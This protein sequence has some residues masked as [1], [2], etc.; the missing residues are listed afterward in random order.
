AGSA[1]WSENFIHNAVDAHIAN[2][3]IASQAGNVEVS[4]DSSARIVSLSAGIG[5]ATGAALNASASLNTIDSRIEAGITDGSTLSAGQNVEVSAND[6]SKIQAVSLSLSG[7]IGA[8]LG[9]A[10]VT[11]TIGTDTLAY[12]TGTSDT[13]KTQILQADDVRVNAESHQAASAVSMG[14]TLGTVSGGASVAKSVINGSTQA[15]VDNHVAIGSDGTDTVHS[16]NIHALSEGT[17]TSDATAVAG[18]IGAGTSNS[19]TSTIDP[20]ISAYIGSGVDVILTGGGS[21]AADSRVSADAKSKGITIALGGAAG[22]SSSSANI[23]PEVQ[24]YIG[25]GSTVRNAAGVTDIHDFEI[26]ANQSPIN[27]NSAA[28]SSNGSAGGL[29]IGAVGT[30]SH[31]LNEGR[32]E[33][34][35]GDDSGLATAV[36]MTGTTRVHADQNSKQTSVASG[37]SIG[38]V[39]AGSNSAYADSNSSTRAGLKNNVF[40]GGGGLDIHA[41]GSDNNVADVTAGSGGLVAGS[42][43]YAKTDN[44]NSTSVDVGGNDNT[45]V[46]VDRAFHVLAKQTTS[47]NTYTDSTTASVVGASGS[48]AVNNVNAGVTATF[49]SGSNIKAGTLDV[50]AENIISKDSSGYNVTAGSGGLAG[51]PAASSSTA[52]RN[53]TLISVENGAVLEAEGDRLKMT[54]RNT[55]NATDK[56]NLDSGGA[57]AWAKAKST[58]TNPVNTNEIRIG[59]ADLKSAGEMDL[60]S[61]TTADVQ[62]KANIRTYGLA[63]AGAGDSFASVHADNSIDVDSGANLQAKKDIRLQSGAG[64][65]FSATANTDIYNKTAI[66]IELPPAAHGEVIQNSTI[67][68]H[69]D[70]FV[71]SD[72]D[73]YLNAQKGEYYANGRGVSTDLYREIIAAIANF[74]GSIFGAK[75]VSLKT[76]TSSNHQE[77]N[78]G[79]TVEGTVRSGMHHIREMI[80]GEDIPTVEPIRMIGGASLNFNLAGSSDTI[81]RDWGSWVEDGFTAGQFIAVLGSGGNDGIYQIQTVSDTALTLAD[82]LLME[83]IDISAK[84]MVIDDFAATKP[85]VMSGSPLL[86][87]DGSAGTVTRSE[88]S[89]IDDGFT[90]GGYIRVLDSANN[91]GTY[92]ITS[93]SEDGLRFTVAGSQLED[94]FTPVQATVFGQ[95]ITTGTSVNMTGTP[96]LVYVPKQTFMER[97]DGGSWIDDGFLVNKNVT[98]DGINYAVVDVTDTTVVLAQAYDTLTGTS[99]N[100]AVTSLIGSNNNIF[101]TFIPQQD[102]ALP[103]ITWSDGNWSTQGF[104][105][106]DTITVSGADQAQNNGS[107][108]IQSVA[109]TV[110]QLETG[111]LLTDDPVDS[112]SA[113][114]VSKQV[115]IPA[116]ET[117]TFTA[118]VPT[119]SPATITRSTG[120]WLDDGFRSGQE[121]T[122]TDAGTSSGTYTI[123]SVNGSVITLENGSGLLGGSD[124]DGSTLTLKVHITDNVA[125]SDERFHADAAIQRSSGTWSED[126]STN[127]WVTITNAVDS[128]NNRTF[129]ILSVSGNL[130]TIAL[131]DSTNLVQNTER[132][133]ATV[134]ASVTLDVSYGIN[135]AHLHRTGGSWTTDGFIAG[136]TLLISGSGANGSPDNDGEYLVKSISPDGT[137]LEL[138]NRDNLLQD[139][140]INSLTA[141]STP[142]V[143]T[144]MVATGKTLHLE[145]QTGS[146]PARITLTPSTTGELW[147]DFGFN[148]GDY[149]QVTGSSAG[150]SGL[151][152]IATVNANVLELAGGYDFTGAETWVT[153]PERNVLELAL[154][155]DIRPVVAS[156]GTLLS[157]DSTNNT[158][159]RSDAADW[160]TEGFQANQYIVIRGTAGGFN[161]GVYRIQSIGLDSGSGITDKWV[162]TLDGATPL[163]QDE[164]SAQGIGVYGTTIRPGTISVTVTDGVE[165]PVLKTENLAVNIVDE[166]RALEEQKAKYANDPNMTGENAQKAIVGI[167]SQIDQL[168]YQLVELGLVYEND[169]GLQSTTTPVTVISDMNVTYIETPEISARSGDI[170]ISGDHLSGHGVLDAPGDT[171]ITIENHSPYY[172]RI[173]N[174]LTVE[175]LGGNITFNGARVYDN[176]T[177]QQRNQSGQLAQFDSVITSKNTPDSLIDIR[178]TYNPPPTGTLAGAPAPDIEIIGAK[179]LNNRGTVRVY[180]K[181]GSIFIKDIKDPVT[182]EV[183]R[184]ALIQAKTVDIKAGRDVIIAADTYHVASDPM[185]QWSTEAETNE[186]TNHFNSAGNVINASDTDTTYKDAQGATIAGNNVF[187]TS[188]VLNINGLVKSGNA[189]RS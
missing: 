51:G 158:L 166:I 64:N 62:S 78:S 127:Q 187:I 154:E 97:N 162:M 11:N 156:A 183:I 177:I 56:V 188:R 13:D 151:Y 31:T 130:M 20:E 87:F 1:A 171:R 133:D 81:S 101:M 124:T 104:E 116:G 109:G 55:V 10:S 144:V 71:G 66:P 67:N 32:V 21:I 2:S 148:A 60:S 54:G 14:A 182:N 90:A 36:Q 129:Q 3:D 9:G 16:L 23:T 153:T 132:A 74:F 24:A 35:I 111:T 72:A 157:F 30:K 184:K 38:I 46:D 17:A 39:A 150:N 168:E 96:A 76:E 123:A 7:A 174:D 100:E 176:G 44:A 12:I 26:S 29:L 106:G 149:I 142:G 63:G 169:P 68:I 117:L 120:N 136:Q 181:E 155:T 25:G 163:T 27:G 189:N 105:A 47:F 167:D 143:G 175:A 37:L 118:E 53:Q 40:I 22:A 42:A 94:E 113:V 165:L 114:T 82:D 178:N 107:F 173:A 77:A 159:T 185:A 28:A 91:D 99:S 121:I 34:F 73:V 70:A 135:N 57:I 179:I 33:A 19:A 45:V 180:N 79:V 103:E 15:Y 138:S 110:L 102:A 49:G 8:A 161:D 85:L 5:V 88:G 61:T 146:Q 58:V 93:V 128:Q 95:S 52:I 69:K 115:L 41:V 170:I 89:W 108:V 80:I 59:D 48:S 98:I 145:P 84:V 152:R 137:I 4:A 6:D 139:T 119:T 92:R 160:E 112:N 147:E 172:L 134:R 43:S 83:Q 65:H 164:A 50:E 125:F 186:N 140:E 126:Y 141:I 86:T 75:P 122:L 18:G 131:P